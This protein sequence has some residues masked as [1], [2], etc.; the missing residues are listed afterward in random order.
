VKAQS[1]SAS[2]ETVDHFGEHLALKSTQRREP[3]HL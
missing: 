3:A 1:G 2:Y